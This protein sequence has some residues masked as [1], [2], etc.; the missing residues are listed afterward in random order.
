MMPHTRA[1]RFASS[2]A[3]LAAAAAFLVVPSAARASGPWT[4]F[5]R[6][7][8]YTDAVADSASLWAA[9][10][11]AGLLRFDRRTR[12][13]ESIVR[14]PGGLASNAL[15]ALALDRSQRLWVGTRGKG[16][17]YLSSDRTR[18]NLLNGFD[19]L[20]SDTVNVIVPEGDT[21]WIGTTTGLAL[22]NG[23]EIVGTLPDGVNPS[24][25]AS[26][27]ITGVVVMGDSL[28]VS[29]L[30]GV[31]LSRV[32][33]S[34]VDWTLLV[35]GLPATRIDYLVGDG[36]DVFAYSTEAAWDAPY[37]LS[38]TTWVRQGGLFGMRSIDSDRGTIYAMT[39]AGIYR[40]D[41]ATYVRIPGA[42]N[43]RVQ[44]Y[45]WIEPAVAPDGRLYGVNRDAFYE[46]ADGGAVWTSSRPVQ[47]P[48]NNI[49]NLAIEGPRLYVNTFAEGIGRYDGTH[50]KLWAPGSCRLPNCIA[51]TTFLNPVFAFAM[52][53]D[54]HSTKWFSNWGGIDRPDAPGAIERMRD[55]TNPPQFTRV[56]AWDDGFVPVRHTFAV[57][58][59]LDS[60]GGH[61]FGMDSAERE[62]PAYSPIGIDYYDSNGVF[63]RNI[64]ASPTTLRTGRILALTTDRLGTVWVGTT[65]QGIQRV[66]WDGNPA[67]TPVFLTVSPDD[68]DDVRGIVAAGDTVWAQS[69][70]NVRSYRRSLASLID[71]FPVPAG[72]SDIAGHSLEVAADGTVWAGTVNGV[73]VYRRDGSILT[74]FTAANS[75]LASDEVR[76]IRSDRATGVLW[77]GTTAGLHRY[78]PGYVPPAPPTVAK[79][80]ARIYPNPAR[81]TALGIELRILGNT[82]DYHGSIYD[83]N[84]R[85]VHSFSGAANAAWIWNGRDRNG[86]L[87]QPGVY[88]L[89]VEAG[90][91]S[92]VLRIA[93]LH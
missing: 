49:I 43:S 1:L 87:V 46:Q 18:W 54:K 77:I 59:T 15:L 19:G 38:G 76:A 72:P 33:Q 55:D 42:P 34:L 90:G 44:P 86:R 84:G 20:P 71:E 32:S 45:L 79:L 69:T 64:G 81:L 30:S 17:S 12:T 78:D 66:I 37:R 3:A 73:R 5:L 88:F 31:Y 10:L 2:V 91:S 74:D 75:P 47:P 48:G 41:G 14:E 35:S 9:T 65:G 29:T 25:F 52:L 6:A 85:I 40:W 67:T 11:E 39:G 53:I 89:R 22:W 24:P 60:S 8:T 93:L 16:L 62:D 56:Q 83:L 27:N 50:W 82:S 51:D 63:V 7:Y 57:A 23:R 61:W 28:F 70:N 26:D 21:L 36:K 80:E 4:T 92:A 68:R 58:S 13:F